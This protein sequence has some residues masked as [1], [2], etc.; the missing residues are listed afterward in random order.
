MST[1]RPATRIYV[2]EH[3]VTMGNILIYKARCMVRDSKIQHVWVS[4]CK[5]IVRSE[6]SSPVIHI[7]STSVVCLLDGLILRD[8]SSARK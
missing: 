8:L 3:I 1:P 2:N 7:N 4:N 6:E 5:V